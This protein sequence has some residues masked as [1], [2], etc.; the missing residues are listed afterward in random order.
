MSDIPMTY[1]HKPLQNPVQRLFFWITWKHSRNGF[2][3]FIFL[4][5]TTSLSC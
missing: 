2:L 1:M 4:G 3:A 5:V